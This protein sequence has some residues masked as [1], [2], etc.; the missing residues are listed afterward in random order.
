VIIHGNP[1]AR[2]GRAAIL[3]AC[4]EEM[5]VRYRHTQPGIFS[6]A[7]CLA[8]GVFGAVLLLNAG[9]R[10]PA[11]FLLT[12]EAA[13]GILFSSLTVVVERS[14]LRWYFGPGLWRYRL[15]LAAVREIAVVRNHWWQGLGIRLAPGLRLYNVSG[16]D[17]VELRL[18][19]NDVRRIG[20]DD[21][22]GLAAAIR[23]AMSSR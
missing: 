9:Y 5:A 1:A 10:W 13:V 16:L 23:A 7:I 14:E 22:H 12:V 19:R 18:G 20:T 4:F 6:V 15:P 21:A 8:S 11:I 2:A 3:A 17:A